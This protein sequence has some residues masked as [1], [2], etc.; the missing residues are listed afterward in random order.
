MLLGLLSDACLMFHI[1]INYDSFD[2][3]FYTHFIS[4]ESKHMTLGTIHK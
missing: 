4:L 2:L 3:L 1:R